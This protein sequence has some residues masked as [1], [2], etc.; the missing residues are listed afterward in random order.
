QEDLT[1]SKLL[2]RLPIPDRA[3][4]QVGPRMPPYFYTIDRERRARMFAAAAEIGNPL[5]KRV[6]EGWLPLFSAPPPPSYVPREVF[7]KEMGEAFEARFRDTANHIA[8]I[9]SRGGRVVLLRLP[10]NGPL[11]ERE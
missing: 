6:A 5:Q 1:L 11:L 4:A 10:V 8:A 2:E 3:A 7:E 9:Q